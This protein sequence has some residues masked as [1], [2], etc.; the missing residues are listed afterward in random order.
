[1]NCA[2]RFLTPIR[3]GSIYKFQ[4]DKYEIVVDSDDSKNFDYEDMIRK[5]S[6]AITPYCQD[7]KRT[8]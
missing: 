7:C 5:V 1:M 8:M 6:E 3:D 2:N 4:C